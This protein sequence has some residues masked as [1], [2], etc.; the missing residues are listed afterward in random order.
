MVRTWQRTLL[1]ALLVGAVAV[2]GIGLNFTLLRL[3]Q[4]AHDP[5]GRL[6]PRAVFTDPAR[7]TPTADTTVTTQPGVDDGSS[8]DDGGSPTRNDGDG[9]D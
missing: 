3:T 4:D 6:S 7:T 8:S 1:G 5:V 2:A 9:D